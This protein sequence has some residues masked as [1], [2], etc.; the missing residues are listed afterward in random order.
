M[1][2]SNSSSKEYPV[3]ITIGKEAES[4]AEY[5]NEILLYEIKTSGARACSANSEMCLSKRLADIPCSKILGIVF[6]N[7][8]QADPDI[9]K[10]KKR[11]VDYRIDTI[12]LGAHKTYLEK[13]QIIR[14]LVGVKK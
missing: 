11:C 1:S 13:V 2:K 4:L 8:G 14:E 9:E 6:N 10:I 7:H 12:D 5:V 3:I